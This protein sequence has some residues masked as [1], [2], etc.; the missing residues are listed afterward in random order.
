VPEYPETQ[1]N[2]DRMLTG[3]TGYVVVDDLADLQ[4]A[5]A[6][7]PPPTP[8]L[9][10]ERQSEQ[11]AHAAGFAAIMTAGTV[12]PYRRGTWFRRYMQD[13][14]QAPWLVIT[15]PESA[16]TKLR[17][18]IVCGLAASLDDSPLRVKGAR[19]LALQLPA[20]PATVADATMVDTLVK[21]LICLVHEPQQIASAL[22][23]GPDRDL[24][25]AIVSTDP[26][27]STLEYMRYA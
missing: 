25:S 24:V 16:V 5:Q 2:A 6:P 3:S 27:T 7:T 8:R 20:R 11:L 21:A 4:L 9:T 23:T 1:L 10:S 13:G 22:P 12:K 18:L 17:E 14:D 15:L 19:V 26:I